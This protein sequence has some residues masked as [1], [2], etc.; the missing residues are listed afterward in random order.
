MEESWLSDEGVIDLGKIEFGRLNIIEA[1]CG[2]GKTTFV[3]KEVW[4]ES[5]CGDLLYLIDTVNGLEAFKERG[6]VKEYEGHY[7]LKHRGITAMTYA[8][9]AVLCMYK[10]DEW[11]WDDDFALIVCDELQ[12]AI[13]WSKIKR[14][15]NERAD[16]NVH[17]AALSEIHKRIKAGAR[18]IAITATPETVRKEF[19]NEYLDVPIRGKLRRYKAQEIKTFK[20]LKEL[21]GQLPAEKRGVI[22]TPHISQM[23]E[24]KE[25]LCQ[26]GITASG[27]WSENNET[28]EMGEDEKRVRKS[29]IKNEIIPDDIRVLLINAASETGINIKS[30]VEYVVVN[31]TNP[32]TQTQ[33]VGRIR[34]DLETVYLR[35]VNIN[36]KRYIT[37]DRLTGWLNRRLYEEDKERLC[38]QLNLRDS[39]GRLFKW[40]NVKKSLRLSDYKV[41]DKQEKNGRRYSIVS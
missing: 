3:E 38:Q 21:I 15:N 25:Q 2:C 7:Y 6:E 16:I 27:F 17:L 18:I 11:L 40:P 22:Y 4:K 26:R 39:R 32:D 33:A 13:K 37:H 35:D 5:M 24:I 19:E 12:S 41:V 1:P 20:N 8:T 14:G 10:P 29:V 31:D 28:Y 23:L 9:F 36:E 34:H 30:P